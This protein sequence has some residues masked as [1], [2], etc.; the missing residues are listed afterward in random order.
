MKPF[1]KKGLPQQ[2]FLEKLFGIKKEEFVEVEVNNLLAANEINQISE[3]QVQDILNKYG[4]NHKGQFN[5]IFKG[6]Y[7]KLLNQF[8]ESQV[9]LEENLNDLKYLE[10]IL[11]IPENEANNIKDELIYHAFKFEAER[12]IKQNLSIED[13]K[14]FLF[15]VQQKLKVKNEIAKKSIDAVIQETTNEIFQD[16]LIP[17]SY[18]PQKEELF[19]L[20]CRNWDFTPVITD[21]QES[22]ISRNKYLWKL[23]NDEIPVIDSP[24]NLQKSEKCFF[25]TSCDWLET[26]KVT[27]RYNYEGPTARI[28]IA[29]GIYY[30]AGSI[31]IKPTTEDTLMKIDSGRLFLTNKRIIFLG[32]KE[33]KTI[34][35]SKILD[36]TPY[37]N[38]VEIQKDTGKSPFIQFSIDVDAFTT[39]LNRI[40]I[41]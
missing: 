14:I 3:E 24:I 7:K 4:Y 12:I 41:E 35:L 25:Q 34:G 20:V 30:R 28:K 13:L 8:L 6:F 16:L 18:S 32:S 10:T 2:N 9:I 19:Y 17:D 39:I 27:K 36:F 29:K 33:N 37:S 21:P 23:R 15:E 38:G 11:G 31:G 1:I 26:R 22:L 5:Q 40:L